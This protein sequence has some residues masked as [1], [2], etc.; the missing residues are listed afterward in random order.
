MSGREG[1]GASI[2]LYIYIRIYRYL[3]IQIYRS[4][5]HTHKDTHT[6]R[7]RRK[8]EELIHKV[9]NTVDH[10]SSTYSFIGDDDVLLGRSSIN[11][12]HFDSGIFKEK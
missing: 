6:L 7:G 11:L 2:Y 12:N 10:S 4:Y 3:D 9:V 1:G 5:T 8:E